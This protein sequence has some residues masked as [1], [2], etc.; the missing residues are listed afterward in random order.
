[1][2]ELKTRQTKEKV[3]D[4]IR[5]VTDENRQAECMVLLKMMKKVTKA[6]P[7]VWGNGV[8]G[9][10]VFHYKSERSKQEGDWFMTGFA[11]RKQNMTIYIIPGFGGYSGIMKKLGK[12]K[13]GGSCLYINK[14]ADVDLNVL[15][16]LVSKAYHQM[17]E[18][19]K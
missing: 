10:G 7:V 18:K 13:I 14:L 1:M 3:L 4:F 12:H 5:A 9:F 17:K 11:P 16:E 15:A 19:Y 2:A 8:V 6:D